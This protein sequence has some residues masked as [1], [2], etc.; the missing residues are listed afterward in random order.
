MFLS[1]IK[2]ENPLNC[3]VSKVKIVLVSPNIRVLIYYH[4]YFLE[5]SGLLVRC[6]LFKR[7]MIKLNF[8]TG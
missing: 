5:I 1:D 4:S 8:P 2:D 7:F 6:I 3:I